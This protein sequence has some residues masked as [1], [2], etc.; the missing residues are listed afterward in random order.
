MITNTISKDQSVSGWIN[1]FIGVLL[2]S[3]SM[4]ATKFAVLTTWKS[5]SDW[6]CCFSGNFGFPDWRY[7]NVVML[8]R[9]G[10][11][12]GAKLSKTL[13]GWQVISWALIGLSSTFSSRAGK[14]R[15]VRYYNRGGFMCGRNQ[16]VC[17]IKFYYP[18]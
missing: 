9:L 6:F 18:L 17:E 16:K 5:F 13:E 11:A 3:G 1:G 2:F 10:Y 7:L 14:H 8:C 15:N 4:P 12:E